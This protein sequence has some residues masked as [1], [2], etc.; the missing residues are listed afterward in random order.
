[1][2]HDELPETEAD[3]RSVSA[4]RSTRL[5]ARYT[6]G[7][8]LGEGGMGEVLS[9]RDVVLDRT[10]AIKVVRRDREAGPFE[11]RF[12]HEA[13]VQAQLEHPGVVPVFDVGR[14]ENG[15]AY[16]TMRQV[17]GK[18]LDEL[19]DALRTGTSNPKFDRHRL[20]TAFAQLC[21]TLEYAHSRGILHRDLK[22]ANVMLGEFGE[23]YALDWGLA[24]IAHEPDVD[25]GANAATGSPLETEA[26]VTMG[27]PG[28]MAPEQFA[29]L[30]LDARADVFA[31]G[32]ILFEIV[33]LEPLLDDTAVKN[34]LR[35][36]EGVWDARPSRRA[37]DRESPPE[38]DRICTRA[39]SRVREQRY[40]SARAL[41]EAIEG[42]LEGERDTELRTT[43]AKEHIARA[44]TLVVTDKDAAIEETNRAL[45][46]SPDDED[47]LALL[48]GLLATAPEPTDEDRAEV[49]KE[50]AARLR[51]AQPLGA[52]LFVV[53]WVTIY[54]LVAAMR[55]IRS[56]SLVFVP[57][58]L[59]VLAGLGMMLDYRKNTNTRVRY[60]MLLVMLA[61]AST[62][63]LVGPFFVLPSLAAVAVASHV[64][65]GSKAHRRTTI[66]CGAAALIVPSVLS[67]IGVDGVYRFTSET[68]FE[69]RG[70]FETAPSAA[71]L[72]LL[73]TG[74]HLILIV[75][76]LIY[77]S[78]F[79][80]AID[81]ARTKTALFAWQ[82]ARLLPHGSSTASRTTGGEG[83]LS[84]GA[85]AT[86]DTVID[87]PLELP[88]T[89]AAGGETGHSDGHDPL[90]LAGDRYDIGATIGHEGNSELRLGR[91]HLVGR[92]VTM[93]MARA[94]RRAFVREAL[95]QARLDHPG[96][97][98]V[99]DAS[100]EWITMKRV[101]GQTLAE[102][103]G[104]PGARQR[105]L[106]SFSQLCLIID[107]AH[108]QHVVHG[109]LDASSVV[110]GDFPEVWIV[111]WSKARA[112]E[113]AD[114]TV[115]DDRALADILGRILAEFREPP[116]ELTAIAERGAEAR[117]L[118]EA[119]DRYLGADRHETLRN[120]LAEKHL[121]RAQRRIDRVLD[122]HDETQR[123]A[124]LHEL[125]RA[126]ALA[127]DRGPAL[128]QLSRLL[129]SPP[130]PLPASVVADV[131]DQ[132]WNTSRRAAP[133]G[134]LTLAIAWLVVYPFYLAWMGTRDTGM[135]IAIAVSWAIAIFALWAQYRL[136][137][138]SVR[139]PFPAIFG[140][141]AVAMT[142]FLLGPFLFMPTAALGA[143]LAYLLGTRADWRRFVVVC[144]IATVIVPSALCV[145]G[146]MPV[147]RF[148]TTGVV[149]VVIVHGA[150]RHPPFALQGVL[151]LTNLGGLL[152]AAAYAA[153]FREVLDDIEAKNRARLKQLSR[154][155]S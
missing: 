117:A 79:R 105:L 9:C 31:L 88:N 104:V 39:T 148:D 115:V 143:G 52:V 135:A 129:A 74:I 98:S 110:L 111:D 64:M 102:S 46:L 127:P 66:L 4:P 101:Q 93:K 72:G 139:V 57:P 48:V 138:K 147:N 23:V 126:I 131:D 21:L 14:D 106:G 82:L 128:A 49:A 19:L 13:R 43:K 68:S 96:I 34:R 63:L 15:S 137:P 40:P 112:F 92:D 121:G 11:A 83:A 80:D 140:L 33:T 61:T 85:I 116:P 38:L 47:A 77:A 113:E 73:L 120:A 125:G 70:L 7:R 35:R 107:F 75:G 103:L 100:D 95:L 89:T 24:K 71:G 87:T 84:L 122:D 62:T 44:R 59:W 94:D 58:A 5:A 118:Q 10:V 130:S 109:A 108:E 142:S 97:P 155:L 28:Y 81:T 45:A 55:N 54:P 50:Q 12:V 65:T 136:L 149:G 150:I 27:T 25:V 133:T 8:V 123:E 132:V 6:M 151:L 146:V 32:A 153:R 114:A 20:L 134:A 56:P 22:P 67:W 37:P 51:R 145:L 60:P 41:Y 36:K 30:P 119:V 69:V 141:L 99:Y 152:L 16:F 2:S 90:L 18:T 76:V 91:D 42:Y 144:S 154:L 26:G 17:S 3:L 53:P 78:N 29:G 1:M 86:A 124:A